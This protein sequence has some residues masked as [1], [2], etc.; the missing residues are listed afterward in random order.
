[1]CKC[2]YQHQ[3]RL[4][5]VAREISLCITETMGSG[6]I[7]IWGLKSSNCLVE[8]RAHCTSGCWCT[9]KWHKETGWLG[10]KAENANT[11][12]PKDYIIGENKSSPKSD[13]YG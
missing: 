5:R 8:K 2:L 3:R 12:A 9:G 13:G 10:D 7:R 11:F 1:M 6:H 4:S